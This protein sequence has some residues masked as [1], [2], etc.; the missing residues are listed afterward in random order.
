[1][2]LLHGLFSDAVMNWIKF[3]HAARIAAAGFRV[4]MPDLRA[5]GLSG[6]SS[7]ARILSAGHP[8]SRS[9]RT[10]RPAGP[11]RVRSRRLFTRGAD[12]RRGHWRR[13]AAAPCGAWRRRPR[14][15]APLAAAQAFLPRSDRIVR[16]GA[17]RRPAL[18]VDS[19]HEEPEGRP[20]RV[21]LL[22]ESFADAFIDWLQAFTMPTLVVCGSEDDDNGSAAELAGGASECG[23]PRSARNA[24]E[25]GHEAGAGRSDRRVPFRQ[26]EGAPKRPFGSLADGRALRAPA[27]ACRGGVAAAAAARAELALPP[28]VSLMPRLRLLDVDLVDPSS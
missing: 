4:I 6:K 5:H 13:A 15:S 11:D 17:A 1:M 27:A 19:V 20:G 28:P 25:F 26:I 18:A 14:G 12:D 22:L 24:H 23:V 7:R 9:A 21:G 16:P 3:G 2:V 10:D 8:R